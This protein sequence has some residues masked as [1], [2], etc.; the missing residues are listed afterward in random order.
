MLKAMGLEDWHISSSRVMN[1]ELGDGRVGYTVVIK[2]SPSYEGIK[3][4]SQEQIA[5]LKSDDAYASNYYYEV[6]EMDFTDGVLVFFEYQAPLDVVSVVNDSVMLLTTDKVVAAFENCMTL[7]EIVKYQ[8]QGIPDEFADTQQ[9]SRVE[10]I[11]DTVEFG[12]T[13]I[14]IK[15]NESDFYLVPAYTFKGTYVAYNGA[16]EAGMEMETTFA[17]INAVDGSIINTQLGY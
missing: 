7:D 3:V 6:V 4:V 11:V 10:A 1:M 5:S 17:V 14:R 15:N 2:A 8:V 9:I 13:R 12:L 16:G